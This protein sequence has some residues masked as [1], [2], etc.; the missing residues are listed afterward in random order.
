[1]AVTRRLRGR[2]VGYV[3]LEV[4]FQAAPRAAFPLPPA[5]EAALAGELGRHVLLPGSAQRAGTAGPG[6]WCCCQTPLCWGCLQK[7]KKCLSPLRK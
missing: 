7:A 5:A 6:A 3:A 4:R 1:M 2:A